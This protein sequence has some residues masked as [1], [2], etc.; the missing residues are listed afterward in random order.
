MYPLSHTATTNK[1]ARLIIGLLFFLLHESFEFAF[2][3]EGIH[4]GKDLSFIFGRKFF[5]E[6]QSFE[7]I[8]IDVLVHPLARACNACFGIYVC[9]QRKPYLPSQRSLASD[10]ASTR[11]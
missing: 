8:V 4:E 2:G 9:E 11:H 7:R 10:S 5:H 6:L 1:K 3:K